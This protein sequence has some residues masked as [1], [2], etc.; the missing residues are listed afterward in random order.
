MATFER[1]AKTWRAKIRR[2]G[3]PIQTMSFDTKAAAE[4]WAR[5]VESELDRG[6][7]VSHAEAARTSLREALERYA[8]EV[9][10]HKKGASQETQRIEH[11]KRQA[12]A[13]RALSSI[14]GADI[15][16]YRDGRIGQ[17]AS[18]NTV[19]L[20]LALLSH[21]YTV[22]SQ[23]WGMEALPNPV[24]HV[25]KPKVNAGR[26][27]RLEEGEEKRLLA[28]ATKSKT[29][30]LKP[31]VE[32]AIETAMRQGEL[33]KL[34]WADVDLKAR[35]AR[36]RD[37]KSGDSRSVPLSK[38]ATEILKAMPRSLDGRVFPLSQ[39]TL[40]HAF[41]DACDEAKL[42]NLRFHDLR[43]EATS[44]LF[45]KDL[46]HMEVAAITG[47]KTLAMLK[48]YTHLRAKNLVEKLG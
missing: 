2:K 18:G 5:Q 30:W 29:S 42:A 20:E 27:R 41:R 28:A 3:Y 44:R 34:K 46:D 37:T 48:R 33:L 15:A 17:G 40:E 21:L 26:D 32:I 16:T 8:R 19:R 12:L 38:R 36:L 22:A 6:V 43:H 11:W 25:R 13:G 10:V 45:E 35:I 4:T 1:R 14:R 23:E 31:I 7:V 47:H 9:T 24:R 39:S